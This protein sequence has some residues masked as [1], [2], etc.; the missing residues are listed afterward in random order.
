M[1]LFSRLFSSQQESE[2]ITTVLDMVNYAAG[3]AS[4]PDDID[5]VLDE[6]RTITAE[7]GPGQQLTSKE[8]ER[9]L[10]VYKQL[11]EYL[12]HREPI[13]TY[14]QTTLRA[15]LDSS[16]RQQLEAYEA[17]TKLTNKR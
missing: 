1:S 8:V 5:R 15:R 12:T 2:Q 13:R 10:G 6:V 7:L 11:E 17:N 3:L 4:N 14:D 16:L 9:L